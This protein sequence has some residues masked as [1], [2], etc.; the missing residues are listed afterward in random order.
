MMKQH[1]R[2]VLFLLSFWDFRALRGMKDNQAYSSQALSW[3]ASEIQQRCLGEWS[4]R[5]GG[6]DTPYVSFIAHIL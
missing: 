2:K 1:M 4:R 5:S 3:E 6:K